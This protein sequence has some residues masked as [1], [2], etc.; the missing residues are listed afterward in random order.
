MQADLGHGL[1]AGAVL[2][3]Y[4]Y[5]SRYEYS[6]AVLH[7]DNQLRIQPLAGIG[8]TP[9]GDV[10]WTIPE[11]K[12]LSYDDRF[13]NR[14]VRLRVLDHHTR[15]IVCSAGT[16]ALSSEAPD[17]PELELDA[18]RELPEALE[19]TSQS[20]LVDPAEVADLAVEVAGGAAA[21]LAAVSRITE[22]VEA[23]IT[24]LRGTTDVTTSA[25]QVLE[26]GEGVCQDKAH[27]ALALL[28]ALG[29]PCRYVSGLLGGQ[30]GETHAWIEFLHPEIGW[31]PSDPTRGVVLPPASDYIKLAVGRDYADVPPISGSFLSKGGTT[32]HAAV[33]S[34]R[35]GYHIFSRADA[36]DLLEDAYVVT[37][38]GGEP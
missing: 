14:V 28:R 15:F 26:A 4:L 1:D 34:V 9:L 37:T 19:Y 24:Y 20:S 11:A 18:V 12:Q 27:L 33:A 13:G 21:L 8:Q 5:A 7:N 31:L 17:A 23:N 2:A 30:V 16:V 35:R 32:E 6:A 29:A 3:S 25:G 22:W 10:V 38:E 36:F